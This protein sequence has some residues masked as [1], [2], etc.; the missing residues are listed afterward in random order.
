MELWNSSYP[1]GVHLLSKKLDEEVARCHLDKLGIKLSRLSEEQAA[2]INVD[3]EGPLKPS[4][5]RY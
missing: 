5:Y 4:Y 3:I 2:Y 1:P